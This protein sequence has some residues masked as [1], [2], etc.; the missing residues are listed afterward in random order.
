MDGITAYN[1]ATIHLHGEATA[2]HS[3]GHI[4]IF[5]ANFG[6]VIIHLPPHHNT[7]Y[8]NT[9]EDRLTF[10]SGNITNV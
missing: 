1:K 3:N 9:Q 7:T 2:A 10:D 6:K 5:A 4:G 8:N